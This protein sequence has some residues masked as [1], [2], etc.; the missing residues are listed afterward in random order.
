MEHHTLYKIFSERWRHF[1]PAELARVIFKSAPYPWDNFLDWHCHW[2]EHEDK[3]QRHHQVFVF[4]TGRQTGEK[5]GSK[6]LWS[7]SGKTGTC[8]CLHGCLQKAVSTSLSRILSIPSFSL[9]AIRTC[10]SR[11][12]VLGSYSRNCQYLNPRS[13]VWRRV[14]NDSL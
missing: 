7:F 9:Y 14:R 3:K 12:L 6:Y 4:N 13:G 10:I 11:N 2:S 8:C 5:N 1:Q